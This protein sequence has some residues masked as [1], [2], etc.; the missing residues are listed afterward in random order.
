M[1]EVGKHIQGTPESNA[2]GVSLVPS[3]TTGTTS[4]LVNFT[5]EVTNL[6]GL[7]LKI[8]HV[9]SLLLGSAIQGV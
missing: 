3:Q 1:I 4:N 5:E 9:C 6:V 8:T 2:Y 7:F